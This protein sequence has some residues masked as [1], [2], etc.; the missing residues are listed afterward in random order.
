M[1]MRD[2]EC[3]GE[4]CML[5]MYEERKRKRGT[6]RAS[7]CE[8]DRGAECIEVHASSYIYIYT[9]TYI[10]VYIYIHICI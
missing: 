5:G 6:R 10:Y 4:L 8:R 9:P 1:R 2:A 7:V 3:S